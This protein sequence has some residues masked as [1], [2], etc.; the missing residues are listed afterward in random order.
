MIFEWLTWNTITFGLT[1]NLSG[2]DVER[3]RLLRQCL[4]EPLHEQTLKQTHCA[5]P[6]LRSHRSKDVVLKSTTLLNLSWYFHQERTYT[7]TETFRMNLP[8]KLALLTSYF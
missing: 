7:Y 3:I 1:S 2:D 6:L 4:S 5:L 8:A